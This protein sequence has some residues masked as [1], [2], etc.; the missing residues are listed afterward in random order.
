LLL[1]TTQTETQAVHRRRIAATILQRP[2]VIIARMTT[3][4]LRVR[5]IGKLTG[6]TIAI[7]IAVGGLAAAGQSVRQTGLAQIT[8][9]GA[10]CSVC[11]D[12]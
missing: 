9:S 1:L 5:A 3:D 8:P 6:T 11:V 10:G 12:A 2:T 7:A 4:R